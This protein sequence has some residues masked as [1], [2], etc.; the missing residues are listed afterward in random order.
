MQDLREMRLLLCEKV[1][2]AEFTG[3]RVHRRAV[4]RL[5][6]HPGKAEIR[7][8]YLQLSSGVPEAGTGVGMGDVRDEAFEAARA[9]H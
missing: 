4:Q 2:I 3:S 5:R 6:R 7:G 1:R 8:P 9:D